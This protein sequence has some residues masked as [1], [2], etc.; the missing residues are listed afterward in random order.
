VLQ[1]PQPAAAQDAPASDS[2]AWWARVDTVDDTVRCPATLAWLRAIDVEERDEQQATTEQLDEVTTGPE[3]AREQQALSTATPENAHTW[4]AYT[5]WKLTGS[6]SNEAVI[7]ATRIVRSGPPDA[8]GKETP[9]TERVTTLQAAY[10]MVLDDTGAWR[11]ADRHVFEQSR[12]AFNSQLGMVVLQQ[13]QGLFEPLAAAYNARDAD[14]LQSV[15]GGAALDQYRATLEQLDEQQDH[16]S[17]RFTGD[18]G[19]IDVEPSGALLVFDGTRSY[20]DAE[21]NVQ[22]EEPVTL[23]HRLEVVDS[24]WKIVDEFEA[25]A[26]RDADGTEHVEGCS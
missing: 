3:L 15:L 8:A 14:A 16:R 20:T 22:A 5:I 11:L 25:T 7:Y 9:G 6:A 23:V 1:A 13:Y 10:R 19:M 24:Q 4:A 17:L 2:S 26:R 18:L 21:G 12:H